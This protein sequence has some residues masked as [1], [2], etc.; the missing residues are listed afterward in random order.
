M[1]A[2]TGAPAV[3]K[4]HMGTYVALA[5]LVALPVAVAYVPHWALAPVLPAACAW[6][7]IRAMGGRVAAEAAHRYYA[8]FVALSTYYLLITPVPAPDHDGRVPEVTIFLV[9]LSVCAGM[10]A[11]SRAIT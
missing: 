6:L 11:L 4:T 7:L 2:S 10:Y 3:Q 9:W 8:L 5:L 1:Q